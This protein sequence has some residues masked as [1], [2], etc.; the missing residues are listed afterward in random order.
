MTQNLFNIL[1]ET[2]SLISATPKRYDEHTHP[3]ILGSLLSG[4][5]LNWW[6]K[7]QSKYSLLLLL[8][9]LKIRVI[10]DRTL[11]ISVLWWVI[12]KKF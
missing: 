4:T 11:D 12:M 9:L 3:L 10:R 1:K 5:V 6:Y 7:L 8:I 2:S